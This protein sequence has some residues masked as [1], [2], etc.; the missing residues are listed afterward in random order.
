MIKYIFK[1]KFYFILNSILAFLGFGSLLLIFY[2][3][4]LITKV[5]QNNSIDDAYRIMILI[6]LSILALIV[7]S[8]LSVI[9]TRKVIEIAVERLR[10]DIFI[11]AYNSKISDYYKK[12]RSYFESII[13]ND[14][15]ILENKYFR[16][17]IEIINDSIQII[18][19]A[20]AIA[21]VGIDNFVVVTLLC[22]PVLIAPS[23]LKKKLGEK[24]SDFSKKMR[25]FNNKAVETIDAFYI[26][27]YFKSGKGIFKRYSTATILVEDSRKDLNY[28]RAFNTSISILTV[29]TL[30]MISLYYFANKSLS[31]LLDLSYMALLF[32][33]INNI[34]NPLNNILKYIESIN[35]TKKIRMNI[36][37]LLGDEIEYIKEAELLNVNLEINNLNLKVSDKTIL[38]NLNFKFIE[39]NKYIIVGES[40]CGKSSLFKVLLRYFDNYE[41][42]VKLGNREIRTLR[43]SDI[44]K[45]ISYI[46]QEIHII[47]DT[48]RN[49]IT[50]FNEGFSDQDILFAI[51]KAGLESFYDRLEEGLDTIIDRDNKNVS[52]G[53]IQR[54]GLARGFLFDSEIYLLDEAT[55]ALDK[56]MSL[57]VEKNILALED[58][59]V[60]SIVHKISEVSGEY[61]CLIFMD[62]GRI[63]YYGPYEEI[64]DNNKEV[65]RLLEA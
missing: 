38:D 19:M 59:I 65:K 20:T 36:L 1:S 56:D 48:F 60:I 42:E 52:G 64:K 54:I 58:K 25:E 32:S 44:Y 6:I 21:I 5:V 31:L 33:L 35:S 43:H 53:E 50:L 57:F 24:G 41:G 30:K 61:D 63:K 13:L 29:L 11:A 37:S 28:Y 55:S 15:D 4:S 51:R 34:G 22:I 18:I 12:G 10:N 17:I 27:K 8:I 47:S 46:S 45:K 14:I 26:S 7:V 49:N 39:G 23:I 40:G 16:S 2:C 3:Y 9:T 62:K